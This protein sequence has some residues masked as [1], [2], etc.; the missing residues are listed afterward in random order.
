MDQYD[1]EKIDRIVRLDKSLANKLVIT[2]GEF[3]ETRNAI[4]HLM[5]GTVSDASVEK[6]INEKLGFGKLTPFLVRDDL[7][8]IMIAGTHLPVYVFSR[9]DGMTKTDVYLE[10]EEAM[11]VV[12]KIA[13]YSGRVISPDAPLLDGRLPDGSRVNA[14][15]SDVTPRGVTLTIRKFQKKNLTIIDLI[16]NDTANS[17]LLA[18][19]WLA[20][21]GINRM[22]PAN[23]LVIGG[24]AS[25]KTTTMNAL[26][27]FIPETERIITIED[28]LELKLVNEHW[29]PMETRPPIPGVS[30]E[31]KMDDLLKN[32]LRMRPDR[33][34]VGEVRSEEALTLFTAMNTGH[35]G[36]IAT[37]HANSGREALSRLMSHPM[38]VPAIMIP[39]V[40][41]LISQSRMIA[42]GRL[43]RKVTEVLEVGG[44]EGDVFQTNTL[45]EYDPKKKKIKENILNGKYVRELSEITGYTIKEIDDE[46]EHRM[47]LID[48]MVK[49]DLNLEEI[50]SVVQTYYQNKDAAVALLQEYAGERIKPDQNNA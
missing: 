44:K 48:A 23:M 30:T 31:V 14:T 43:E 41:I 6:Y 9:K 3:E 47:I 49:A 1:I 21:E 17:L 28:T 24:T 46:I 2:R 22:K 40:D 38:N 39:A 27:V 36:V 10:P 11:D 34:L 33:I 35:D 19:L 7:E 12:K 18:F 15:L 42:G 5:R 16:K 29:I 8:E 4:K 45:F 32:A 25:G 13:K 26:S 37:L 50:H 20:I